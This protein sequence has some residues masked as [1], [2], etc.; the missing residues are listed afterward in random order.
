MGIF[1]I[2]GEYWKTLTA[3]YPGL[4]SIAE[5]FLGRRAYTYMHTEEKDLKKIEDYVEEHRVTSALRVFTQWIRAIKTAQEKEIKLAER[6]IFQDFNIAKATNHFIRIFEKFIE[7]ARQKGSGDFQQRVKKIVFSLLPRM[8]LALKEAEEWGGQDYRT[9]LALMIRA[10]RKG[11]NLITNLRTAIKN[12]QVVSRLGKWPLRMDIRAEVKDINQLESLSKQLESIDE[13]LESGKGNKVE[14][15]TKFEKILADADQDIIE[16]F[17]ASHLIMKR[18]LLLIILLLD[19]EEIMQQF[20]KRWVQQHFMPEHPVEEKELN[21]EELKNKLAEK[22]HVIANG[23][24]VFIKE[25]KLLEKELDTILAK[26][27]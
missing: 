2:W 16:M 9:L 5:R 15:L 19:D 10:K 13:D 12:K 17:K 27:A 3:R 1:G 14:M 20:G 25:E 18:D 24:G 26:V 21:I 6:Q 4:N 11:G 7:E 23:L 8:K 22:A